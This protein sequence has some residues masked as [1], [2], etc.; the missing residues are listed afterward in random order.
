MVENLG[1]TLAKRKR[2]QQ[3]FGDHVRL[4]RQNL[5][6]GLLKQP[7]LEGPNFWSE[8][9]HKEVSLTLCV[10]HF[11]EHEKFLN[12]SRLEFKKLSKSVLK[13]TWICLYSHD[14]QERKK[15]GFRIC[16][17]RGIPAN[18]PCS[19]SAYV[20]DCT[21]QRWGQWDRGRLRLPKTEI[22][23]QLSSALD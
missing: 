4:D 11:W 18:T 20:E 15:L 1:G 2:S 3:S 16:Q 14:F 12:C 23:S 21:L 7:G 19:Q 6:S 8:E 22:C 10:F 13:T 17:R 9:K 5:D